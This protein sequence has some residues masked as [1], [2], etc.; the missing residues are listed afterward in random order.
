MSSGASLLPRVLM[1]PSWTHRLG[2]TYALEL[3][4]SMG[5]LP[6]PW[7][8]AAFRIAQLLSWLV[9]G[10]RQAASR[11]TWAEAPLRGRGDDRACSHPSWIGQLRRCPFERR[12]RMGMRTI[13]LLLS[14]HASSCQRS[15]YSSHSSPGHEATCRGLA[16]LQR[17]VRRACDSHIAAHRYSRTLSQP[18]ASQPGQSRLPGI[19]A[20]RQGCVVLQRCRLWTSRSDARRHNTCN[21]LRQ[22]WCPA[23]RRGSRCHGR[24]RSLAHQSSLTGSQTRHAPHE[25]RRCN[26]RWTRSQFSPVPV[27]HHRHQVCPRPSHAAL[28][29]RWSWTPRPR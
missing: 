12:L 26:I 21:H 27:A 7:A 3:D 16:A 11:P 28:L 23:A 20:R 13:C 25:T 15:S 1:C 19:T 8:L 24:H 4:H 6:P 14:L 22:L 2:R 5:S 10:C 18:Q 17:V 9:R 29:R